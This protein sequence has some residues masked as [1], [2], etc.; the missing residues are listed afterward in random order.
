MVIPAGAGNSSTL[1]F[2][3]PAF[4]V[5]P[6]WRGEL[7]QRKPEI[8]PTEPVYPRWRGELSSAATPVVP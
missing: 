3:L 5:Y 6:R 7:A 8:K 2:S 4:A 1:I